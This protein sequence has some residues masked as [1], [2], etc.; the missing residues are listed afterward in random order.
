MQSKIDSVNHPLMILTRDLL[1]GA[2]RSKHNQFIIDDTENIEQ[3]LQSSVKINQIFFYGE[4]AEMHG[5]FLKKLP[6]S[7]ELFPKDAPRR[8]STYE[9]SSKMTK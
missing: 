4:H 7:I 1:S 5:D 6:K 2:G 9:L 8:L 3:A